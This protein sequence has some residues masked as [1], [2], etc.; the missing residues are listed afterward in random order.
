MDTNQYG[1]TD[2]YID[3]NDNSIFV[4]GKRYKAKGKT[5]NENIPDPYKFIRQFNGLE[6]HLDSISDKTL[7]S[8]T[9]SGVLT[10]QDKYKNRDVGKTKAKPDTRATS[11]PKKQIKSAID[12]KGD[13][14]S[15]DPANVTGATA[16]TQEVAGAVSPD[17]KPTV[18]PAV[19]KLDGRTSAAKKYMDILDQY[20]AARFGAGVTPT[21]TSPEIARIYGSDFK[22]GANAGTLS[23]GVDFLTAFLAGYDKSAA[24]KQ[25]Y[26]AKLAETGKKGGAEALKGALDV[27]KE[28]TMIQDRWVKD[29]NVVLYRE[30]QNAAESFKSIYD[31]VKET[32]K[33]FTAMTK[34]DEAALTNEF[35]KA[36]NPELNLR[37]QGEALKEGGATS[38]TQAIIEATKL[39][40]AGFGNANLISSDAAQKATQVLEGVVTPE[41]VESMNRIVELKRARAEAQFDIERKQ[42]IDTYSRTQ[43]PIYNALLDEAGVEDKNMVSPDVIFYDPY[44]DLRA[45]REKAKKEAA[46]SKEVNN[47]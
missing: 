39:A 24:A 16:G 47:G 26:A 29:P 36:I 37:A 7:R 12:S 1:S 5:I 8:K 11:K 14:K 20:A 10:A 32:S 2:I 28:V 46:K 6:K 33:K 42:A 23:R 45:A 27:S 40:I 18:E 15:D 13:V 30:T 31:S 9:F 41:G 34:Q 35:V 38:A 21:Q 19:P 25:A 4:N 3:P 44:T 43:A 22:F 17:V